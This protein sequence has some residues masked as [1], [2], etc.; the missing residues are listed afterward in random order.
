MGQYDELE[1]VG[2]VT[3]KMGRQ[4]TEEIGGDRL[5]GVLDEDTEVTEGEGADL[6]DRDDRDTV[7]AVDWRFLVGNCWDTAALSEAFLSGRPDMV[8]G[9]KSR[10]SLAFRESWRAKS[11]ACHHSRNFSAKI[12]VGS[13]SLRLDKSLG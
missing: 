13:N 5:G 4:V 11:E 6:G 2:E 12:L 10:P 3:V 1:D 7:F 8:G 9:G